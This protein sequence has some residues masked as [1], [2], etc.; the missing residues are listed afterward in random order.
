MDTKTLKLMPDYGCSPLWESGG[1]P[2]NVEPDQLPL[3]AETKAALRA[4]A[5]AYDRTLNQDYPPDSGFPT[6]E[7]EEAFETEGR[8]LWKKLQSELGAHYKVVYFSQRDGKCYE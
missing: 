7:D 3:T 4:W 2:Y 1:E 6:P 5:D 8:Q